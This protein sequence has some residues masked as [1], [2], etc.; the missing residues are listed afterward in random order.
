MVLSKL[1]S[2]FS[3]WVFFNKP[4]M[5]S[6][7]ICNSNPVD[8]IT[9]FVS[10]AA[11]SFVFLAF[12]YL[13]SK[14]LEKKQWEVYMK[15]EL[16]EMLSFI[17]VLFTFFPFMAY[18][19]CLTDPLGFG[20]QHNT[21]DIGYKYWELLRNNLSLT[22]ITLQL[23]TALLSIVLQLNYLGSSSLY[24]GWV[25]ASSSLKLTESAVALT[26]GLS[27][28]MSLMYQFI[29]YGFYKALLPIS[30][31]LRA[32]SPTRKIGGSLFGLVVAM[33]FFFPLISSMMY[34]TV[35]GSMP[36][37]YDEQSNS[38]S[39]LS[40]DPL[41][42]TSIQ[43]FDALN[44][45]SPSNILKLS[46]DSATDLSK[47]ATGISDEKK[48]S[49]TLKEKPTAGSGIL[50]EAVGGLIAGSVVNIIA[51][52]FSGGVAKGLGIF[53]V[54][55]QGGSLMAFLYYALTMAIVP[56]ALGIGTTTIAIMVL[57]TSVKVFTALFGEPLDVSN[58]TRLI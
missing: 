57:L 19:N 18:F 44:K 31:I 38:Y 45:T 53:G 54:I 55:T 9:P 36:I 15:I 13:L 49:Q 28:M 56:A 10:A 14:L 20:F 43:L 58:L 41:A 6:K 17:V 27:Y 35:N 46:R 50:I 25:F 16:F 21:Y 22:S 24:G 42:S 39:L 32:F 11:V 1:L 26:Y 12:F 30:I 51:N 7:L 33:L 40:T 37:N 52:K 3:D 23:L 47:R 29:T 5:A 2:T 8:V 34:Y 48:L 4:S